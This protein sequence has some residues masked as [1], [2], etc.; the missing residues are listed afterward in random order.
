MPSEYRALVSS[1]WNECLAPSGPFD[2]ISFHYPNLK[3]DIR[4]IF[5]KYTANII[6]LDEA[7]TKISKLCA[8]KI[9]IGQMDA[10]LESAF[11]T[12]TGVRQF[13][14]WCAQN[15]ILF[16]INTTGF[17]GYF[18][19][20][21]A[22]GLLPELPVLCAHPMV[23]FDEHRTQPHQIYPIFDT[24]D[25]GRHTATVAH[26]Y[27]IRFHNI[28]ILG[29]SGGDGPHFEWGNSAGACLIGSMAKSS[30]LDYCRARNI[31]LDYTIG[32]CLN[33]NETISKNKEKEFNLM[34]FDL[35]SLAPII[36]KRICDTTLP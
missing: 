16:M 10:Y 34:D 35:M 14:T 28:F 31:S 2:V 13:M 27:Q 5:K 25:K 32:P 36:E 24:T 19:R 15:R 4:S 18:Q 8:F 22:K 12:Y 11:E 23:R 17:M 3:N 30:L 9:S 20:A 6:S 29:D 26:A 7:L 1:D 21:L 33:E